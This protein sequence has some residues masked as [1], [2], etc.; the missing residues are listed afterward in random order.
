MDEYTIETHGVRKMAYLIF[1]PDHC[2][3]CRYND[4]PFILTKLKRNKKCIMTIRILV[5][6]LQKMVKINS[7]GFKT[8]CL[9]Q[10]RTVLWKEEGYVF[11]LGCMLVQTHLNCPAKFSVS[12]KEL[13]L[14]VLMDFKRLSTAKPLHFLHS[15]FLVSRSTVYFLCHYA[16]IEMFSMWICSMYLFHHMVNFIQCTSPNMKINS[17]YGI[18]IC[19]EYL[20]RPLTIHLTL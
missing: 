2:L 13:P 14:A 15:P 1:S 19:F 20:L 10:M 8:E 9:Q 17:I 3:V 18:E 12:Q 5:C 16:L 6:T 11:L 4:R 7:H